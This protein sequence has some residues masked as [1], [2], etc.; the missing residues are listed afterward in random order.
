MKALLASSPFLVCECI[1]IST[2]NMTTTAYSEQRVKILLHATKW[3]MGPLEVVQDPDVKMRVLSWRRKRNDGNDD[4]SKHQ[5]LAQDDFFITN[6]YSLPPQ[7][8]GVVSE[9]VYLEKM[10]Q[11]ETVLSEHTGPKIPLL[12]ALAYWV[13]GIAI[14]IIWGWYGFFMILLP[15]TSFSIAAV[16]VNR[17]YKARVERVFGSWPNVQAIYTTNVLKGNYSELELSVTSLPVASAVSIQ[18]GGSMEED[19]GNRGTKGTESV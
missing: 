10:T 9:K 19:N 18:Y 11:L 6:M 14:D 5:S 7:L 8:N 12:V 4:E 3:G 17:R 15:V 13:A 2:S 1:R 16:I